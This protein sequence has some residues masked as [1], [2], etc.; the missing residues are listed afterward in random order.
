MKKPKTQSHTGKLSSTTPLKTLG[1][2]LGIVS[3]IGEAAHAHGLQHKAEMGA[4][5]SEF[6]WKN[7]AVSQEHPAEIHLLAAAHSSSQCLLQSFSSFFPKFTFPALK[8]LLFKHIYI[9]SRQHCTLHTGSWPDWY[10]YTSLCR[11][12]LRH[13]LRFQFEIRWELLIHQ[14]PHW[15]LQL[16]TD[17]N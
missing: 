5:G 16:I 4:L 15:S 13:Y 17:A 9:P 12:R 2:F 3:G 11:I 1:R 14:Y 8:M 10:F 7:S 6:H